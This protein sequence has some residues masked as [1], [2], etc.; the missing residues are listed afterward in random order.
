MSPLDLSTAGSGEPSREATRPMI[1]GRTAARWP[2]G[3]DLSEATGVDSTGTR[4]LLAG[5]PSI[6]SRG[7]STAWIV[8]ASWRTVRPAGVDGPADA[9]GGPGAEAAARGGVTSSSLGVAG[10]GGIEPSG[11]SQARVGLAPSRIEARRRASSSPLPTLTTWNWSATD[12]DSPGT[13]AK[14]AVAPGG[15]PISC[16]AAGD[17]ALG[18]G[19][20]GSGSRPLDALRTGTAERPG[21]SVGASGGKSCAE[22]GVARSGTSDDGTLGGAPSPV[23]RLVMVSRYLVPMGSRTGSNSDARRGWIT[24]ASPRCLAMRWPR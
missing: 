12:A 10:G 5:P 19:T 21:T 23:G 13:P 4:V 18:I 24:G 17:G 7:G 22:P 20:G 1:L 15:V 3:S 2:G 14:A 16:G 11:M 6:D 8:V 9:V